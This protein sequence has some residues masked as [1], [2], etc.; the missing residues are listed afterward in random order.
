MNLLINAAKY[1]PDGGEI[2]LTL[3]RFE[4]HAGIRIRDSG[5]GIAPV[6]LTRIFELFVQVDA[7]T[8]LA[9]GGCGIG[10][11]VVRELVEMHG[12]TVRA[13]SAGL[14]LGSEFTVLLPTFC[15][16]P[17]EDRSFACPRYRGLMG[18]PRKLPYTTSK[19][20]SLSLFGRL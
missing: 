19:I 17:D 3:E 4:R 13:T 18:L 11:A 1:T 9:E 12:G 20:S 16:R 8:K 2:T 7:T 10:L 14:G 6:Q 15:S 5:I